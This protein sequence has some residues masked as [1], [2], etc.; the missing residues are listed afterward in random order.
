MAIKL[1]KSPAMIFSKKLAGIAMIQLI[2]KDLEKLN[3]LCDDE[4]IK[5]SSKNNYLYQSYIIHLAASWQEFNKQLVK[6]CFT[7]LEKNSSSIAMNEIARGRVSELLKKFNTPN[8]ENINSLYKNAFGIL[9]VSKVWFFDG[10]SNRT[11]LD[12]LENLLKTRH[13][14]AHV[15]VSIDEL[16]YKNNFE[17]MEL[18]YKIAC[19]T[20]NHVFTS[21]GIS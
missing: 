12:T 20:E 13:E 7:A 5:L 3:S 6:Y 1:T 19:A 10:V 14:I 21:L 16:N 8:A 2:Q 4:V 9:G 15:G 17:S 18:I 11:A